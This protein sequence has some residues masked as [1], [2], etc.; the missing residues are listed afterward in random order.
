[1]QGTYNISLFVWEYDRTTSEDNTCPDEQKFSVK[2]D[3]FD[4]AYKQAGLVL[5][6]IRTNPNVGK[7]EIQS[8]TVFSGAGAVQ[9]N[10]L[11]S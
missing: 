7:T 10:P 2:A 6:G 5:Y 1:M 3:N 9:F 8:I 11:I 4:H